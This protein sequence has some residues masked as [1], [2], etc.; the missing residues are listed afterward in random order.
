M[1]GQTM[2][3]VR[4]MMADYAN[5][6]HARAV[7]DLL[8]HY[9]R[10]PMGGGEPLDPEVKAA[11]VPALAEQPGAFSILAYAGDDEVVGLANCFMG[12]STFAARPLINIHDVVTMPAWRG[13]GVGKAMFAMIETIARERGACK[14]TLEVL[15]GN[16]PAKGLYA[17]LGYGDFTLDP[18]M[19]KALFWQK[20]LG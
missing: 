8:D 17:A 18:A 9:A 13:K 7:A 20:R 3:G 2:Q 10:D 19:G 11:L 12:F 1:S 5:P 6:G 4:A 15:E 16:L 14:V